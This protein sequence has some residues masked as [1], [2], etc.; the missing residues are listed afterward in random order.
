VDG[1][2]VLRQ[3]RADT[4]TKT[5]P[6]VILTSSRQDTDILQSYDLGANSF[7]VKPVDFD[8]FSEAI[9]Q[10]GFYWLVLNEPHPVM[11]KAE[12]PQPES[13]LLG[14]TPAS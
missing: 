13:C 5:L 6:V 2:E 8:K 4:R 14:A 9:S 11:L 7:I 1:I 3:L 12:A 10:L